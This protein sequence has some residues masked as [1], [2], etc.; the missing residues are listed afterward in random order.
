[1]WKYKRV[2]SRSNV[3]WGLIADHFARYKWIYLIFGAVCLTG[4]IAGFIVGFSRAENL[5]LN[6]LPDTILVAFINKDI[7]GASL[8]FSRFFAFLGL[9]ILVWITNFKPF[10]CF[11]TFIIL[12][13]RSFLI[14]I[15]CAILIVLYQV[16]GIIN[17][18]LIFLPVHLITLFA[19][20]IWCTIC[21]YS[22]CAHKQLNYKVISVEFWSC[23]RLNLISVLLLIIVA[24]TLEAILMPYLT[25]SI[26]IGVS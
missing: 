17:V 18:V 13:Y 25:S 16:G 3:C 2:M 24:Y 5:E 15:N 9:I 8:F 26:F 21:F 12:L 14:G 19:L 20:M 23:S 10:L 4:L 7:A 1:M 11:I 22:N 6:D